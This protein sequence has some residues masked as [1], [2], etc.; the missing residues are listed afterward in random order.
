MGGLRALQTVF[1]ATSATAIWLTITAANSDRA[2]V[3]PAWLAALLVGG[4][5]IATSFTVRWWR[6]R[7]IPIGAIWD[8]AE[9]V[10]LRMFV[11]LLPAA[12]GFLG[13][14]GSASSTVALLG[15]GFAAFGLWSAVPSAVD[16]ARHQA[17]WVEFGEMPHDHVWGTA[18]PDAIPPWEDPDGGHGHELFHA[19]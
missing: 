1:F 11:A 17:L 8:Y 13:G 3:G 15:A 18:D 12:A 2:P 7:P 5:G 19:H 16:Y 10:G 14:I 4:I 9:T 6:I